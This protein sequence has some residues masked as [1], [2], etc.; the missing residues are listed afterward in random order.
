MTGKVFVSA[1][2]VAARLTDARDRL[3]VIEVHR[4]VAD[5][6]P[7]EH[8]P[9]A[10]PA[11]LTTHLSR[12]D[13]P[14]IDGK[15]PLPTIAALQATLRSWDI[16]DDTAV[17]VYDVDGSLVAARA[18]WVLQW[19][20]ITDVTILDGGLPAWAAAGHPVGDLGTPRGDGTVTLSGGHRG[21]LDADRAAALA[22]EGRLVDA[23][24][25]EV[26]RSGHIPHARNVGNR[27]TVSADGTLRPADELRALY[28]VTDGGDA[29][30]L[31]CGGGVAAAH[32]VAVLAHLG[33]DAPLYVGSFSAW[34]ADPTRPVSTASE[35]PGQLR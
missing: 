21:Q 35:E 3:R 22:V 30:G 9:G 11:F 12:A 33:F 2:A 26:F 27:Q 8:V 1:D 29:P 10:V 16:H 15:R 23:R 13:A 14:A 32:G 24:S 17:V 19:A 25:A 4:E 18:W 5:P 7:G 31:Y 28:G 20:G 34:T 6:S